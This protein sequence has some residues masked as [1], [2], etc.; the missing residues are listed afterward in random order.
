MRSSLDLLIH[1]YVEFPSAN[2]CMFWPVDHP[3]ALSPARCENLLSA[4]SGAYRRISGDHSLFPASPW[5]TKVVMTLQFYKEPSKSMF[6]VPF[7]NR[8]IKG[9]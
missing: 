6:V 3:R 4:T 2:I 9:Q 5:I 8:R 1:I 7:Q